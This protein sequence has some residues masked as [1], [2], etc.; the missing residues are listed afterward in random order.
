MFGCEDGDPCTVD[1]CDAAGICVHSAPDPHCDPACRQD[2][3]MTVS[4]AQWVYAPADLSL[5]FL[6]TVA[7][8]SGANCDG[9]QCTCTTGLALTEYGY[10]LPLRG[11]GDLAATPWRCA[12]AAC[13]IGTTS[14]EPLRAGVGYVVWGQMRYLTARESAG[15]APQ[16]QADTWASDVD[17]VPPSPPIDAFE[18]HGYCLSTRWDHVPGSYQAEL[19]SDGRRATFPVTLQSN[20]D[21][22]VSVALGACAGCAEVGLVEGQTSALAYELGVVAFPLTLS[23]GPAFVRLYARGDRL[24]GDLERPDGGFVGVLTLQRAA[25]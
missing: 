6:G 1:S 18:V 4:S 5:S 25:Q 19:D 7:A 12:V 3:A 24:I 23:D 2:A 14:C 13:D 15:A 8:P 16:P 20:L 17:A 9:G 22:D 21:G 10:A 11:A